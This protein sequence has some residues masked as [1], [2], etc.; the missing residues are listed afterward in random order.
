MPS[1][2]RGALLR[3]EA[4]HI[5]GLAELQR[6]LKRGPGNADKELRRGLREAAKPVRTKARSYVTNETGRHGQSGIRL[7]PS[8]RIGVTARGA[9]VYSMAPHAAA[10]DLG[11]RLG[12]N[13]I[14]RRADA[15][16]YMSRA[17][18]D[19]Q[20]DTSRRMQGVLDSV[21]RDFEK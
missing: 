18:Q 21:G 11:A 10:Q 16:R 17:V 1:T 3:E 13:A 7:A 15:S 20:A 12:N 5:D 14:L 19:S 6:A 9:S 4:I 2:R 8:I